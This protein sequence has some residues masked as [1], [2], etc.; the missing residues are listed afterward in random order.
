MLGGI[1]N[2][3]WL[4]ILG[5]LVRSLLSVHRWPY[6]L[7]HWASVHNSLHLIL[8]R[9]LLTMVWWLSHSLLTRIVRLA[10]WLVLVW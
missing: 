3:L 9:I 1:A 10:N 4:S 2:R 5:L 8:N 6:V 7:I